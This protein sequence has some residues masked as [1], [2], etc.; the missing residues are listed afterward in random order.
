MTRHRGRRGG[1]EG[2]AI[3][4]FEFSTYFYQG[5]SGRGAADT[6]G[7]GAQGQGQQ[8]AARLRQRADEES[9]RRPRKRRP[10]LFPLSCLLPTP[11]SFPQRRRAA[12]GRIPSA[13]GGR[14]GGA[15]SGGSGRWGGGEVRTRRTGPAGHQR[16]VGHEHQQ[17]ETPIGVSSGCA[18]PSHGRLDPS[19]AAGPDSCVGSRRPRWSLSSSAPV[20]RRAAPPPHPFPA[21]LRVA[22]RGDEDSASTPVGGGG[23]WECPRRR[24]GPT[25]VTAP[26]ARLSR[27]HCA[28]TAG[29]HP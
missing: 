7:A 4:V 20:L 24:R 11:S 22:P 27:R 18:W 1:V 2:G 25:A 26:C 29:V 16:K 23:R 10:L 17:Q 5:S 15:G 13:H 8:W 3:I 21:P 14:G 19:A 6:R 28:Q 12:A 9:R